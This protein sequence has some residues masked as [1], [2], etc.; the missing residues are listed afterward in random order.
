MTL[1]LGHEFIPLCRWQIPFDEIPDFTR[2]DIQDFSQSPYIIPLAN[3][4]GFRAV[5]VNGQH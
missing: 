5:K 2:F 4:L 1:K 3:K